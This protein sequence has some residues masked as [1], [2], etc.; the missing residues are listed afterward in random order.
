[1]QRSRAIGFTGSGESQQRRGVESV[2]E[3]SRAGGECSGGVAN[4]CFPWTRAVVRAAEDG[5]GDSGVGLSESGG[6]G[7]WLCVVKTIETRTRIS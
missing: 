5:G 6:V 2:L 4:G 7:F 1:M 3:V